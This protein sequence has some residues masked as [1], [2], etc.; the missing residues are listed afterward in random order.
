MYEIGWFQLEKQEDAIREAQSHPLPDQGDISRDTQEAM[1][2]FFSSLFLFFIIRPFSSSSFLFPGLE[3]FSFN[4]ATLFFF[5][6]FF[7]RLN[8]VN[9]SFYLMGG[10]I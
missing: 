9:I 6:L 7:C 3:A 4:F 10:K 8:F 1:W 2:E 5:F